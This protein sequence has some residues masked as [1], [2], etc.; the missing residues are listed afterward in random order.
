[1][2][3]DDN[4]GYLTYDDILIRAALGSGDH[5]AALSVAN[6]VAALTAGLDESEIEHRRERV[7]RAVDRAAARREPLPP[8]EKS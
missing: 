7:R 1:M 4:G 6:L 5:N 2:S 8:S 3:D